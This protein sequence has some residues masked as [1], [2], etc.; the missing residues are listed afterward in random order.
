MNNKRGISAIV[1]TVLIVLITIAGV[2][3]LWTTVLPLLAQD[4]AFSDANAR[5]DVVSSGGYTVY[6]KVNRIATVQVKRG[7]DTTDMKYMRITFKFV[8][9]S[10][11]SVVDAPEPNQKK[12]YSFDL[13][14][15]NYPDP[16]TVEV[17]PIFLTGNTEREGVI[18]SSVEIG[19][20]QLSELPPVDERLHLDEDYRGE[21]NRCSVV[22]DCIPGT[23]QQNPQCNADGTCSYT[24]KTAG[25]TCDDGNS[26]TTNDVCDGAGNCAGS[27]AGCT[28]AAQC[29]DS[30]SCTTD[31]CNTGSCSNTPVAPVCP[32]AATIACGQTITPTN[33]CGSCTGTGTYC[34]SGTCSGG[35]C[36]VPCT[37][38]DLDGYCLEASGTCVASGK[39]GNGYNDCNDADNKAWISYPANTYHLD[40]DYDNYGRSSFITTAFCSNATHPGAVLDGTDCDDTRA[41]VNP[42]AT[43]SYTSGTTCADTLN[44][45]CDAGTDCADTG[46][47]LYPSCN[48][49][50][51]T[52]IGSCPYTISTSGHYYL[53]DDLY[54]SGSNCLTVGQSV[55][56]V[57]INGNGKII[58]TSARGLN[59]EGAYSNNITN[60]TIYNARFQISGGGYGIYSY[61]S[62]L[63][64]VT[65]NNF[66]M[67]GTTSS[68]K[69][70]V[71]AGSYSW[72]LNVQN[73]VITRSS[74]YDAGYG[75]EFDYGSCTVRGNVVTSMEH[76]IYDSAGCRIESNTVNG[77]AANYGYAIQIYN[78]Y[79][80][81]LNNRAC[82]T[83][84][85]SY[86]DIYSN[87]CSISYNGNTCATSNCAG[88]CASSCS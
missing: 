54:S 13:S 5:L 55:D 72:R 59:V 16:E 81:L 11:S 18:T 63:L 26:A 6:D 78:Q 87:Y 76:G 73:N 7:A 20:G 56:N 66:D 51:G 33:G 86:Q 30:N 61:Y 49:P 41:T 71:Y 22:G 24:P 67:R 39:C 34:A 40:A 3:I 27:A 4:A 65:A 62:D 25:T 45:D 85:S 46:C 88:F 10:Y 69:Y 37:D 17:S 47:A 12:T 53:N 57:V 83:G 38:G 79:T 14:V 9:N 80:I 15:G 82:R 21:S 44:N 43:E 29:D 31:A 68:Y 50:T 2:T 1:A 32:S 58:S 28:T 48:V 60:V 52:A 23:C 84:T 64:N 74:T 42:T 75:M 35:V 77:T 70:G 19:F 8:G 36:S